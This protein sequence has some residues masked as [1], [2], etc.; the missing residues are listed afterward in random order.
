MLYSYL[1][2]PTTAKHDLASVVLRH[3][4]VTLPGAPGERADQLQ[5]LAPLLADEVERA[6]LTEL[7]RTID[8]PLA[9]VLAAMERI[10]IHVDPRA[11]EAMSAEMEREIRALESSIWELAGSNSTSIRPCSSPKFFS[12][13]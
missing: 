9:P 10:G 8:L 3:R 12:T 6:G 1:L 13:K 7:Y 2:R 4:N 11:L 5:H